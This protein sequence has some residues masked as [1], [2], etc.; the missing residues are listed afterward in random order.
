M[1][2]LTAPDFRLEPQIGPNQ[3]EWILD[4]AER[5]VP[6]D[7]FVARVAVIRDKSASD[8]HALAMVIDL[9]AEVPRA[10]ELKVFAPWSVMERPE[11]FIHLPFLEGADYPARYVI[12]IELAELADRAG[13][14]KE[15]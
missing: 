12:A 2:L 11:A 8:G 3:W 7:A 15:N 6:G 14:P 9:R 10:Q 1:S 4:W 5:Q 13:R